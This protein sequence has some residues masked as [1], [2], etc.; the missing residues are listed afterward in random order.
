MTNWEQRIARIFLERYPHSAAAEGGRPLRLS[1]KQLFPEFENSPPDEKESFLEA[2]EAL[3]QKGLAGIRWVR[4][5]KQ[6]L[7]AAISFHDP[8]TLYALAGLDSPSVIAA[9]GRQTAGEI[10]RSSSCVYPELFGYIAENLKSIDAVKGIDPQ[11]VRDLARLASYAADSPGTNAVTS[12]TV[13]ITLFS[14]SKRL[15]ELT[16]LFARMLG[17]AEG[18]GIA[19]PDFS[20]LDR[21]FP[22]TMIAGKL[23]FVFREDETCGPAGCMINK[24]G[25]ILG[26]PLASIQRLKKIQPC[27]RD[28]GRTSAPPVVLMIENK[29]T[30]Y[31]LAERRGNIL[32]Q[33]DAFIYTAGHPNRAVTALVSILAASGFDFYHAG[34]LDVEGIL[35]L[36]ELTGIAGKPVTPLRMDGKTF[37]E[38]RQFGRTLTKSML[39]RTALINESIRALPGITAL[40]SRIEQSKLGIEQEIIDY[41]LTS[42][43]TIV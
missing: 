14:N 36:Q 37:D 28:P 11:A 38:Y 35:I 10:S 18:R 39:R 13:S 21:A 23:Q 27:G 9:A 17:R 5:K 32:A 1:L 43:R 31:A 19:V 12:R 33:Y 24:E 3:E 25:I 22:E 2:A 6:E 4:L 34:D 8:E 20:F 40:I 26:L 29:E 15:E 7:L 16:E 41:R 42:F 30:F